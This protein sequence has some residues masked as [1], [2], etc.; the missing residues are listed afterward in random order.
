MKKRNVYCAHCK[1]TLAHYWKPEKRAWIC[2]QCK[3]EKYPV[4]SIER[5]R[6]CK[7]AKP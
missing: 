6:K 1:R 2:P 5:R 7:R 3:R 4:H